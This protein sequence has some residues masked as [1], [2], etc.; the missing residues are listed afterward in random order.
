LLVC[1]CGDGQRS[2][3]KQLNEFKQLLLINGFDEMVA[4]FGTWGILR[5]PPAIFRLRWPELGWPL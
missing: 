3:T 1:F 5:T 4:L 2:E